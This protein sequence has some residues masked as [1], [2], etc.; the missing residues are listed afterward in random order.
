MTS[1]VKLTV[2]AGLE[3]GLRGFV[4]AWHRAETG[5]YSRQVRVLSFE[6][7]AALSAVLTPE[8]VRLLKHVHDH[9]ERSVNALA[10]SLDRQY[11]RVHEDV[12]VLER[13]GLVDR[14]DGQVRAT[15]DK[16]T[17]EIAL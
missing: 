16:L 4:D 1:E 6:S 10:T 8:R 7:W 13:A 14:S 15:A 9:P 12:Q 11:R 3:Q 5:D 17:A 2:G